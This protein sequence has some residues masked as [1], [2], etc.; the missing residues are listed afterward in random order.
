MDPA[1]LALAL[2]V[3][4]IALFMFW[5]ND[6]LPPLPMP[7]W[8]ECMLAVAIPRVIILFMIYRTMGLG[9]WFWIHLLVALAVYGGAAYKASRD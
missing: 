1:F 4:R 2:V 9:M 5:L 7:G 6:G 3:P 8:S